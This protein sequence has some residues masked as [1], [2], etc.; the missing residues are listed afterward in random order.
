MLE[1]NNHDDSSGFVEE[2]PAASLNVYFGV[3]LILI[4]E[5]SKK[6]ALSVAIGDDDPEKARSL[7]WG[8]KPLQ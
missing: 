8:T 5:A 7:L 3:V 1:V 4:Q 2:Q 6:L